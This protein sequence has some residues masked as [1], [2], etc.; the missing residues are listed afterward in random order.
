MAPAVRP[1]APAARFLAVAEGI[2]TPGLKRETW[3]TRICTEGTR[4]T[5]ELR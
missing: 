4:L 1:T 5:G 3:R 2:A